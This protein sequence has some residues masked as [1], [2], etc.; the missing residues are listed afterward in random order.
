M[1]EGG[2]SQLPISRSLMGMR[3]VCTTGDSKRSI[4]STAFTIREGS[5]QSGRLWF[6]SGVGRESTFTFTPPA[7]LRAG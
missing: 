5:A 6:T 2:D 1:D 4:S 7:S 3:F